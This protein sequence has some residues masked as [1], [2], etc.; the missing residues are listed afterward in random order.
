MLKTDELG[1]SSAFM[2][3]DFAMMVCRAREV[4]LSIIAAS[5]LF[6]FNRP[7]AYPSDH[8]LA[9]LPKVKASCF[10]CGKRQ[11]TSCHSAGRR[12]VAYSHNNNNISRQAAVQQS[13]R[14]LEIPDPRGHSSSNSCTPSMPNEIAWIKLQITANNNK[15]E[16][17]HNKW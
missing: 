3:D 6:L 15:Q 11:L 1:R 4:A 13:S 7:F 9:V 16:A 12:L 10:P 2:L 17:N 14:M 5:L 8:T